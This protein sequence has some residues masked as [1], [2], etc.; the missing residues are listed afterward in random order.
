MVL[1]PYVSQFGTVSGGGRREI[2]RK[3]EVR[4]PL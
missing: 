2:G 3:Q 4:L 1:T